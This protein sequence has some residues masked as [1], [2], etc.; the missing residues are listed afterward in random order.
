MVCSVVP[1]SA[2]C[3]PASNVT[4]NGVFTPNTYYVR[5]DANADDAEGAMA[6]QMIAYDAEKALNA[7]AYTRPGYRFAGWNT[8]REATAEEPGMPISD[9]GT[10]RN[11]TEEPDG[12]VTLYAQWSPLY[13]PVLVHSIPDPDG[14]VHGT[15]SAFPR[16]FVHFSSDRRRR[17][18]GRPDSEKWPSTSV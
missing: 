10:V 6:D 17:T 3:A 4:V 2:P 8:V 9:E 18:S 15:A 5:F 14:A 7:N 11:L 12:T 13:Y 1:E 16:G